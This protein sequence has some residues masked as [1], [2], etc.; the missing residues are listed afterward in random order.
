MAMY[1]HIKVETP[2]PFRMGCF[3][4]VPVLHAMSLFVGP[5]VCLVLTG[6]SSPNCVTRKGI[7]ANNVLGA[8][9]AHANLE[10]GMTIAKFRDLVV[11]PLV[12]EILF[13][14]ITFF[15]GD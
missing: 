11:G 1:Y 2:P 10:N 12:E 6:L 3:N 8:F 9:L 4:P 15:A 14:F 5:L 13:R 7:M